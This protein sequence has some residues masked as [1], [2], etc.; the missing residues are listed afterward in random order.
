MEIVNK[1]EQTFGNHEGVRIEAEA[2]QQK[3]YHY[4]GSV[5]RRKG[6]TLYEFN[7]ETK[8]L[9]KADVQRKVNV[10]FATGETVYKSEVTYRQGCIYVQALN[11]KNARKRILKMMGK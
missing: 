1:L 2:K 9:K 3:E 10:D 7:T 6:L 8:E 11:E 4:I 5:L